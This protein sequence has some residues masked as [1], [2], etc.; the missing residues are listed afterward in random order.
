M[1]EGDRS[2][3]QSVE[4]EALGEALALQNVS[5]LVA[6]APPISQFPGQF[7]QQMAAMFQQ[8]AESM[9]TQAPLQ[10]PVVQPQPPAR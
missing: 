7:A 9:P 1:E 4:T 3:E 6:P 10:A 5:G 8:M 2:E